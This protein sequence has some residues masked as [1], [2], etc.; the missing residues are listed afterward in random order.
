[1]IDNLLG[2]LG[3]SPEE[4]NEINSF[5][6]TDHP[7][8][9]N[10]LLDDLIFDEALDQEAIACIYEDNRISRHDFMQQTMRYAAA[11]QQRGVGRH[12]VVAVAI[13]PCAERLMLVLAIMRCG[14]IFL[15]L[16][17]SQ[18]LDRLKFQVTDSRVKLLL[19]NDSVPQLLAADMPVTLCNVDVLVPDTTYTFVKDITRVVTD[20]AYIIYTSGST[21]KPKA[22]LNNH[23]S[24]V[25]RLQWKARYLSVTPADIICHKT[26]FSFDVSVWEQ[27]LPL[28]TGAAVVIAPEGHRG[29]PA[30]LINLITREKI[31][32]IHFIPTMLAAFLEYEQVTACKASLRAIVCSG[33]ELGKRTA[34]ACHTILQVPVYNLYGPTEAAIDV[35]A[36]AFDPADQYTYVPIGKPI[37]NVQIHIL[38]ESLNPVPINTI[39]NLYIGGV[40]VGDG[41]LYR[42]SLTAEKFIPDP[43]SNIP[44]SRMYKTGDLARWQEDGAV[45][46]LGRSDHQVKIR[47]FRIETGEIESQICS[48]PGVANA[49]VLAASGVNNTQQLLAY[50]VPKSDETIDITGLQ[51]FLKATLPSYMLPAAILTVPAFPL[52]GNGKLDRKAL[53]KPDFSSMDTTTAE[54]LQ[55]KKEMVLAAIWSELLKT[56]VQNR[57]ANFF[58]LGGDSILAIRVVIAARKNELSIEVKDIFDYPVLSALAA[59]AAEVTEKRNVA[60]PLI[61]AIAAANPAARAIMTPMYALRI[62][63]DVVPTIEKGLLHLSR[64]LSDKPRD[65]SSLKLLQGGV[66]YTAIAQQLTDA[67][68]IDPAIT[69]AAAFC[70]NNQET[71]LVMALNPINADKY[72]LQHLPYLLLHHP[73][74]PWFMEQQDLCD[75]QTSAAV[76]IPAVNILPAQR[77]GRAR[78]SME[79]LHLNDGNTLRRERRI[80]AFMAF[81]ANAIATAS[82]AGAVQLLL[83]ESRS[84]INSHGFSL[85]KL[86][87]RLAASFSYTVSKEM[88][89][90]TQQIATNLAAARAGRLQSREYDAAVR[91]RI[92]VAGEKFDNEVLSTAIDLEAAITADISAAENEL[93]LVIGHTTL[94]WRFDQQ[95]GTWPEKV[96]A[97]LS[98]DSTLN[99]FLDEHA[100]LRYASDFPVTGIGVQQMKSISDFLPVAED[101]YPLSPIQEG[102]LLRAVYWPE[103]DAY[104]NQN[105]IELKGP[106]NTTWLANAWNDTVE[107]YEILRSGFLWEG[108]KEPLQYVSHKPVRQLE[109]QDWRDIATTPAA[110]E[111]KLQEYL[112]TD[113][114]Q[115]FN[116]DD[117]GLFRLMLA[118]VS[119]DTYLL[120]WTHH[121]ILL[122][123][124]CLALIWG[125]VFRFYETYLNG[126]PV[127]KSFTREYHD[128]IAWLKQHPAE[129]KDR[130]FWRN[131]LKGFGEATL[132]SPHPAH[133]EGDFETDRITI[134]DQKLDQ[135]KKAAAHTGITVNAYVQAA[136]ALLLG[137]RTGKQDVIHGIAVSGRPP[138]LADAEHIV[139][140]FINTIPLRTDL[141]PRIKLSELLL[142]TQESFASA[143]NHSFL[144][145]A[146]ILSEWE[147]RTNN[148]KRLFDNLIAF[149][150]YPDEHLPGSTVGNIEVKDRFCNEKTEYPIGLI[151]LPGP[152]MEF[153]F[154]YDS[155]HFSKEE[156]DL[157]EKDFFYLMDALVDNAE[158]R[159]ASLILPSLNASLANQDAAFDNIAMDSAALTTDVLRHAS[160][161][162]GEAA[163]IAKTSQLTWAQLHTAV[164]NTASQLTNKAKD[165][166]VAICAERSIAFVVTVLAAWEAGLIPV[167]I[168]P[169]MPD[170]VVAGVLQNTGDPLLAYTPAQVARAQFAGQSWEI[171]IYQNNNITVT[172]VR[173]MQPIAAILL[174]SGT[175]G[176]PK[177]VLLT[178]QGLANRVTS[179]IESYNIPAPRMLANAAPGFDIGLWEILFT[180]QQGGT[181]I[182]ADDADMKDAVN[183][184]EIIA[185]HDIDSLH[186]VPSFGEILLTAAGDD[187]YAGIKL[188][189]TGGEVVHPSYVGRLMAK[190]P[191][192]NIWQGYGPTE[193]SVSVLDHLCTV[194]DLKETKV[195]LGTPMKGCRV[196][197][198]DEGLRPVTPGVAGM[199]YIGG[200]PLAEGYYQDPVKTATSFIPDPYGNPGSRMYCTGDLGI[201]RKDGKIQFAGRKDRQVKIRGYRVELTVVEN[202]LAAHPLVLQ[203]IA[204]A[205]DDKEEEMSLVAF[206][207]LINGL[208]M[209]EQAV[210]AQLKTWQSEHLPAWACP[211]R[212]FITDSFPLNANGKIDTQKLLAAMPQQRNL[213]SEEILDLSPREKIV[214]E[215]WTE[216]LKTPPANRQQNFFAAG[217]HSLSA[218]R[219][220]MLLQQRLGNTAKVPVSLLFKYGTPAALAEAILSEDNSGGDKFIHTIGDGDGIPLVLIHPVE[221]ISLAYGQLPALMP[222][223]K[224]IVIDDP[225]FHKREGFSSLKE[226]AALY[227]EWIRLHTDDGAVILAGWSFG[228]VVALEVARIMSDHG[229]IPDNVILIDSYNLSGRVDLLNNIIKNRPAVVLDENMQRDLEREIRRNELLAIASPMYTYAGNVTL[230]KAEDR[231]PELDAD[232]GVNNGW[233]SEQ[234]PSLEIS[235]IKGEH[236]ALFAMPNVVSL[237]ATLSNL[238]DITEK[239]ALP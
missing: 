67:I 167:I 224:I 186:L 144:P 92:V 61:T 197:L 141:S 172:P 49:I 110:V 179:T 136:W 145:L 35:T 177:R 3:L 20:V 56:D 89:L 116:M 74:K 207:R 109:I 203:A 193:A 7:F 132:F 101:L 150:N 137:L 178:V 216:I 119:E 80:E 117:A 185:T 81:A 204:M 48:Y 108:L 190:M 66:D 184:S 99:A 95:L 104:L 42:P 43:F 114:R 233:S 191:A 143:N 235:Y 124:W 226:M 189:I 85:K 5:N 131:N 84:Y 87:G 202:Q 159:I 210:L 78:S 27:F 68:T 29:D 180:L 223:R 24:I 183:I 196:Y 121:H 151:V 165:G 206:V 93:L 218:M 46:F 149:E 139:G 221:G 69:V 129:E 162:S 140:L 34:L 120:I 39:G 17:P 195:P 16:D 125:D 111:T 55:T 15:P 106:V 232:L 152:P 75:W 30:A 91:F 211:N 18:P 52:T 154:N 182:L 82:A 231:P 238:I 77:M 60:S 9:S 62:T 188:L 11:L 215:V 133:L 234:L 105:V 122:D 170:E 148:D 153:H 76:A 199:I 31:S 181:L 225:R 208:D 58:S 28:L 65:K 44:G 6:D 23:R 127:V 83:P 209:D 90:D 71:V 228:G 126:K 213:S 205:S 59:N 163:V 201:L 115:L 157:F 47:G 169:A 230:L 236:H 8:N 94:E 73:E 72:S 12:D 200:V 70:R 2:L 237:A 21:G 86:F 45:A 214:W 198:L 57:H 175:T 96:I 26:A 14:A 158:G 64:L 123:G 22:T 98:Q 171:D 1:M 138:L 112:A 173:S 161:K 135:L 229:T 32:I 10:Q 176:M 38:D 222:G 212:I 164:L 37:Q 100:A 41:Y 160:T 239:T 33:E 146:A 50:L 107:K 53:P 25:N 147:G 88:L 113:R 40:A 130:E 227:T 142:H 13:P 103:S 192:A 36:W 166:K 102:L 174:T 134:A 51:A 4:L 156:I 19:I 54:P 79:Q 187:V 118:R 194:E 217:G 168:N 63:D 220:C 97:Q 219:F 128:Y 155:R